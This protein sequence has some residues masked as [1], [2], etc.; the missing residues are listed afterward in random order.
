M[1]WL[2]LNK[3]TIFKGKD[4]EGNRYL[5]QFLS[6]YK[7]VFKPAEINAGCTNCLNNYYHEMIKHLNIMAT[8]NQNK[9]SGYL[10]KAKYEG[11]PMAFGSRKLV[12]NHNLTDEIAKKMIEK[13]PKGKDLFQVIPEAKEAKPTSSGFSEEAKELLKLTRE[14]LNT[15]ALEAGIENPEEITNKIDLVNEILKSN[16]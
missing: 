7:E 11:I 5:S 10:L 4:E 8:Q 3:E 1:N 14:D 15:K 6:D 12:Y 2:N 16:N 9:N 13:H